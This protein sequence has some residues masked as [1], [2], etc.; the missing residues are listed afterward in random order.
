MS[1]K[2]GSLRNW[3]IFIALLIRYF[4]SGAN[5]EKGQRRMFRLVGA[6][7]KATVTQIT[8]FYNCGE[9]KS[10]SKTIHQSLR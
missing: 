1:M 6:D 10:I 5:S 3:E 7:R 9:Q 8:T 4:G 2:N